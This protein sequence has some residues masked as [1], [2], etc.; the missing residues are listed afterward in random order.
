M[1]GP[2]QLI[3]AHAAIE[4]K[5]Q[6]L[7]FQIHEE[8]L[9]YPTGIIIAGINGN[10]YYLAK[11]IHELTLKLAKHPP[12]LAE[13]KLDKV[14]PK[15]NTTST[16]LPH[17]HVVGKPVVIVDDVLNTGRTMVYA[18][19]TFIREGCPVI[20]TAVLADRNHKRFPISADFVGISLSTTLQEHL[21][22]EVVGDTMKLILE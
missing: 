13:I 19:S 18:V 6:R 17:Q 16:N 12:L 7:A 11:R 14:N 4:K 15:A 3:L 22:F 10:G 20:R 1:L 5:I 9:E 2:D 8:F 21:N